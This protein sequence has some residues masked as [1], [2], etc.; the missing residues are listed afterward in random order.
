M[1]NIEVSDLTCDANG[2]NTQTRHGITLDG[3]EIAI[4]RVKAVHCS[5]YG[6]GNSEC[7][8]VVVSNSG[9]PESQGNIIEECEVSQYIGGGISAI[10][11]GGVA[12]T[13]ISGVMRNNRVVL[14]QAPSTD[15]DFGINI[16]YAHDCLVDGNDIE[17]AGGGIYG[18]TGGTTNLTFVNNTFRNCNWMC[19]Y[20]G[21]YG[22]NN[23]TFAFNHAELI[24][25]TNY[26][27]IYGFSFNNDRLLTV[28]YTNI[29]IFGN[30]II[31]L[32]GAPAAHPLDFV[33]AYNVTG[34]SIY[35][36][37]VDTSLTNDI[38][39]CYNVNMDNNLNL[40]GDYVPDL[41]YPQIGGTPVTAL[42]VDLIASTSSAQVLTNLGLPASSLAIVTN[43]S[44]LPVT[45]NTNLTVNGGLAVS[46]NLSVTGVITGAVALADLPSAVVTNGGPAELNGAVTIIFQPT[47]GAGWYRLTQY[48]GNYMAGDLRITRDYVG[49]DN[50]ANDIEVEYHVDGYDTDPNTVGSINMLHHLAW[51]NGGVQAVRVG[52]IGGGEALYLDVYVATTPTN[53]PITLQF[54]G[55]EG[56]LNAFVGAYG[57]SSY[58]FYMGTTNMPQATKVL[59]VPSWAQTGLQTS[60]HFVAGTNNVVLNDY[61]GKILDSALNVV[62]PDNGGLGT[63]ASGWTA[64]L[65]PVTTGTGTFGATPVSSFSTNQTFFI[66]PPDA[67]LSSSGTPAVLEEIQSLTYNGFPVWYCPSNSSCAIQK[68]IPLPNDFW[69]G[70]LNFVTSWNV[71]TTVAGLYK[72]NI[73]L[74]GIATNDI[75][76]DWEKTITFTAPSTTNTVT[77]SATNTLTT[78]NLA[79]LYTFIYT[80]D[81]VQP[82][83][84]SVVNGK[85]QAQ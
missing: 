9:L 34:L 36:N 4:R 31:N 79:S 45:I 60:D 44:T 70:K 76:Q 66:L 85:V 41:N 35:N 48:A 27:T 7:W 8:G 2:S 20:R 40:L 81:Q 25:T 38:E 47:N 80:G 57:G 74:T 62:Q 14:N 59:T 56:T 19:A 83:N 29:F 58:P 37:S 22:R 11:F 42:G 15:T 5:Y 52:C 53:A 75:S 71:R 63:N 43:G 3:S 21:T 84:F 78:A 51:G 73:G 69:G 16:G 28:S 26:D 82:G 33:Q 18:D 49:T 72:F 50:T 65:L 61:G 68:S 77:I 39:N 24:S 6:G 32:G 55:G 46:G 13:T 10:A 17:G 1:T 54:S 12:G 23:L 64:G 67:F 30:T